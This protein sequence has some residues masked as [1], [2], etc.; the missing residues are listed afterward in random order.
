MEDEDSVLLPIK[1][2]LDEIINPFVD[3]DMEIDNVQLDTVVD[4]EENQQPTKPLLNIPIDDLV[5]RS[6][7]L[8]AEEDGT[9]DRATV[10]KV[11]DDHKKVLANEPEMVKLRLKVNDDEYDELMAYDDF[12][13]F[14][15][16]KF[17]NDEG[18]W[19]YER[20]LSHQGPLRPDD[21]NYMG[22]SYNA[23]IKWETGE[24]TWE[25]TSL[26]DMDD[27]KV[28][29]AIYA[30][31]NKLL[32]VPGW[33]KYKRLAKCTKKMERMV[34]QSK[35]KSHKHL[36]KYMF[37]IRIPNN[38]EEAMYLDCIN[39]N[40]E[41]A[42]AEKKEVD[43]NNAIGTYKSLRFGAR[44]PSNYKLIKVHMVYAVKHDGRH[45]AR[46][47]AN[48]N[49]TGPITEPN[50]S[51]VVSLRSIRMIAFIAELNGLD[52]WGVDISCT[53][54]MSCTSERVCIIAGPEFGPEL[55][56]HLLI[57]VCALYGLKF[58]G[59]CW[60]TRLSEALKDMGFF[61][62][63]MDPDVWMHNCGD[64]YKYIGTYVDDLAIASKNP[65]SILDALIVDYKFE[66]KGVGPM[67]RHLGCDFYRDE[68]GTLCQSPKKYIIHLMDTY[69]RLFGVQPRQYTSPLVKGD[70]PKLDTS[71][72]LEVDNIK[73][74]QTLIGCLQWLVS[75][76]HFDTCTSVMTMS[77]FQ[78]MPKEG[79]L[80]HVK[81]L[82]GYVSKMRDAAICY[83]TECPD[84]SDLPEELY[85]WDNS[86]YGNVSEEIPKDV[87]VPLG[88][89]VDT[90]TFVDANLLH[91][92]LSRKAV[93]GALHMLNKMPINAFSRKQSTVETSTFGSEFVAVRTA[94]DQII[95]L[96]L[97]LRYMGVLIGRSVL[98]GDNE[99]VVTNSTVPTSC[100]MK[101]HVALSYHRVRE[102]IVANAF[103]F[104]HIPGQLNPADVLSKHWGYQQV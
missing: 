14:I 26:L 15:D 58:S 77:S 55:E 95:D 4:R 65:Q 1:P 38:H 24:H 45:K 13:N 102:A 42:E 100:L 81:Q 101:R 78:A 17:V 20:I 3:D 52:L 76:G 18:I 28:D 32:D 7:L 72:E 73:I 16:K 85:S 51:G 66:L 70:H 5:G 80:D 96:C 39:G 90:I 88:N 79:H 83:R 49:M 98:F 53:Y 47:V 59:V 93:M 6:Y 71:T 92:L 25:P 41:W 23:L 104:F 2:T 94:T 43:E 68:D 19:T 50:Y 36:P 64:H 86:V 34:K 61:P 54:L 21:P 40:T 31:D 48:G 75:L 89:V 62:C 35:L 44:V 84:L 9:Q 12:K 56:G 22:S 82:I 29:L 60:H 57:I 37:G 99:S 10:I 103:S 97:T 8:P 67:E 30:R 11:H 74:Y 63:S 27:P 46:L 91:D 69:V 87:P 33:K